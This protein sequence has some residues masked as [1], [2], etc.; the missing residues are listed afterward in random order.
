MLLLYNLPKCLS[1]R[2]LRIIQ[3]CGGFCINTHRNPPLP[4]FGCGRDIWSL[5]ISLFCVLFYN[6]ADLFRYL[7]PNAFQC[8]SDVGCVVFHKIG[9]QRAE[10]LKA[11]DDA[12]VV[13]DVFKDQ[14]KKAIV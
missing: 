8:G 14:V 13:Y 9:M 7:A 4:V 10:T 11:V 3:Q 1:R 6:L 5:Q 2:N 12:D